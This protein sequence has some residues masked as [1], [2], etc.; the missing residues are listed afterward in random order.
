MNKIDDFKSN[1]WQMMDADIEYA[2][3]ITETYYPDNHSPDK[4]YKVCEE[5]AEALSMP[6]GGLDCCFAIL[7]DVLQTARN[8]IAE[9]TGFDIQNDIS[10][11]VY[12]NYLDSSFDYSEDAITELRGEIKGKEW[13]HLTQTF[14]EEVGAL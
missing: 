13:S 3:R 14:L 12:G 7:N 10:I 9:E 4:L 1:F 8:E 11:E 6:I 2:L 5:W